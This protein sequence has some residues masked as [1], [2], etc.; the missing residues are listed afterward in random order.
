MARAREFDEDQALERA[1]HLFWQRGYQAASLPELLSATGLSRS[2]LYE[3]FGTKRNLL[4]VALNRYVQSGM[5]GLAA[6]IF[7][8]D[9]S[10][11]EIEQFLGNMV[12]HALDNE[13]PIGCFVNNC[14]S[15]LA[16]QD[17]EVRDALRSAQE[18]LQRVLAEVVERGQA[19]G[20]ITTRE[21]PVAIARFLIG[22]VS[23]INAT[24]KTK[25]GR[26]VLEDMRRVSLSALDP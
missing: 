1:M 19:R 4:L 11:P 26:A 23:G 2:S 24:A 13:D 3:T 10:R 8:P 15:E 6:P 25:P 16:P 7:Q 22:T 9:A 5:C 14:A 20:Q 17:S 21:A 18:G 12:S